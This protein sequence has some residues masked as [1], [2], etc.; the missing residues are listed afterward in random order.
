MYNKVDSIGNVDFAD[1]SYDFVG[2]NTNWVG[3]KEYIGDDVA[4]T[5]SKRGVDYSLSLSGEIRF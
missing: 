5:S 4:K 3:Y 1:G 2:G